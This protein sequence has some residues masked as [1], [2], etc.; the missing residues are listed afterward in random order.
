TTTIKGLGKKGKHLQA[1]AVVTNPHTG[2]VLAM[3]GGRRAGFPGY[4]RALRAHRQIGSTIKPLIYLVALAQPDKWSLASVLSDGPVH[5]KQ[6]DG[7]MWSPQ[8]DDHRSHGNVL[9]VNALVHSWNLATIHLGMA[10]GVDKIH[11]FLTSFG[12][13]NVNPS[14][15]LLLGAL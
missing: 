13:K 11:K 10:V 14:P 4:N 2:Q 3:T 9:L 6:P 8:N 7:S 15:S 12:L 1:A 5:I